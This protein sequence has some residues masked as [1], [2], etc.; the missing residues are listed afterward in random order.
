[1][2]GFVYQLFAHARKG[3]RYEHGAGGISHRAFSD[4]ANQSTAQTSPAVRR[5]DNQIGAFLYRGL[6]D[7]GWAVSG[8]GRCIDWNTIEI[9]ALQES[10]HLI[11]T[12]APRRVDVSRRIVR[13]AARCHHNRAKV[14]DVQDDNASTNLFGESNRIR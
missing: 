2:H 1:M 6:I 11:A 10:S 4:T 14:S 12:A 5:D 9:D 7:G 8:N 3:R 13:A